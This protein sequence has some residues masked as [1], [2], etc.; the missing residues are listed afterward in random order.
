MDETARL[1]RYRELLLTWTRTVNLIGP[2]AQRNIDAHIAEAL[3][4]AAIL[5]PVGE[6]LDFGSGG[7]LP[8]IPMA[9]RAPRARFHLVEADQ[10]KW[11]FLK[12]AVRACELNSVV[13]GDRLDRVVTR[14]EPALR[15]SL[16]TS[17]AVGAPGSWV[18]LLEDRMM[19]EGRIALFEGAPEA[20]V[21]RGWEADR[22]VKLPRGDSN[23]LV[24]LKMFHVEL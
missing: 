19:P 13:H 7:G 20:P 18:P 10:K 5:E 23:Y 9:I 15:F 1:E 24:I 12:F 16:I 4:A 21:I 17:R 3:A 8:G 22:I 6:V 14:L 11:A 2:E